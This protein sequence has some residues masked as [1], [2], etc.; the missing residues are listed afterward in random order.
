VPASITVL[1]DAV[2]QRANVRD[3]EDVPACRR[4]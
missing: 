4:R 2:L 3:L 1:N